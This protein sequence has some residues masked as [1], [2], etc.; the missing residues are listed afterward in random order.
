METLE[1]AEFLAKTGFRIGHAQ[2]EE[3]A[4]GCTVVLCEAGMAAGVD[5]RGSA[6]ATRETDL[7]DPVNAVQAVHAVMLS[8]GSAFGLDAASGAMAFLAE[9]GIGFATLAGVVP[10]VCGASLFD[11]H[12]GKPGI[13]PDKAMGYAACENAF[14]GNAQGGRQGNVGAGTGAS[15]GKLFGLARSMKS[16]LG[17]HAVQIGKLLCAALVAVNALGDV[18]DPATGKPLAGLMDASGKALGDTP[19]ALWQSIG[20]P[21]DVFA[22]NTTIGCILTNARLGKAEAKKLAAMAHDGYARAIFPAHTTV[23]GDAIFALSHGQETAGLDGLGALAAEAM[24]TAV[25]NAARSAK[26]AYGLLAARD[27][28]SA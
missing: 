28:G 24:A 20:S 1:M 3:G 7:L 8:G 17:V 21:P 6:P 5:V 14:A 2:S 23:D 9:R 12:L 25:A 27:L 13:R 19:E 18:H 22:G 10:I 11:L 16:G 4:T 15:V 26:A